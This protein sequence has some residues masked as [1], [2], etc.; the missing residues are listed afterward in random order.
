MNQTSFVKAVSGLSSYVWSRDG[1]RLVGKARYG[2]DRG[3]NF[4]PITALARTRRVGTFSSNAAGTRSA[5]RSLG[6]TTGVTDAVLSDS[7]R[8]HAQIVRGRLTNAL[9]D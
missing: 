8:G 3:R 1:N 4:N 7:N 9:L 6:L 5:A 2:Y